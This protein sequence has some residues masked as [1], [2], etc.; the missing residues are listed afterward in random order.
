MQPIFDRVAEQH[1][2]THSDS[3][4]DVDEFRLRLMHNVTEYNVNTFCIINMDET[5]CIGCCCG[6]AFL[7]VERF[8]YWCGPVLCIQTAP[9]CSFWV[10]A[11]RSC[12]IAELQPEDISIQQFLQ[13]IIKEQAMQFYVESGGGTMRCW[14]CVSHQACHSA[15]GDPRL[16][17]FIRRGANACGKSRSRASQCHALR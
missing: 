6:I 4:F 15:V 11:L 10:V 13:H 7:S 8:L 9:C 2:M 17:R 1:G 5:V 16:Q 12:R 3:A 14:I